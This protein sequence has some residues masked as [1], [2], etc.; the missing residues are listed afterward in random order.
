MM[1]RMDHITSYEGKRLCF[2]IVLQKAKAFYA[3]FGF[4]DF[5][6]FWFFIQIYGKFMFL[7]I[8]EHRFCEHRPGLN[9]ILIPRC[10]C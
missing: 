5:V 3:I 1:T 8:C 10:L 2:D 4:A 7:D 9:C 6:C